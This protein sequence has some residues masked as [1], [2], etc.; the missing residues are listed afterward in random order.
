[1]VVLV[2]V[3]V[4]AVVA[5]ALYL[6]WPRASELGELARIK[7]EEQL[8]LWQ[9]QSLGRSAAERMRQEYDERRR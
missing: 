2:I 3:A 1:M 6:F 4:L 7:G 9:L 5:V 8:A